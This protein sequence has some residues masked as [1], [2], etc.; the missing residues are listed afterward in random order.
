M[1]PQKREFPDVRKTHFSDS[2]HCPSG[3]RGRGH[4]DAGLDGETPTADVRR[5]LFSARSGNSRP[6][7]PAK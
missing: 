4:L 2:V 6:A 7:F 5:A 1:C 3:L